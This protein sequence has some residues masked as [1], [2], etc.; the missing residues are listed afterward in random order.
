LP[1]DTERL[2]GDAAKNQVA[3]NPRNTV[4]DAKRLIGRHF[5]DEVVQEDMKHWPFTVKAGPGNKP[6]IEGELC[7]EISAQAA[8]CCEFCRLATSTSPGR[9][10]K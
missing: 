3:M 2:I 6:M 10:T 1:A 8:A 9:L 5:S 4:F 7:M